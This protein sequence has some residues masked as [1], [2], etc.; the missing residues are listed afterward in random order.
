MGMTST[1]LEAP[2]DSHSANNGVVEYLISGVS[3]LFGV[4]TVKAAVTSSQIYFK[5]IV[6]VSGLTNLTF[7]SAASGTSLFSLY[8]SDAGHQTIPLGHTK[9]GELLE[10]TS[11]N[12]VTVLGNIQTFPVLEGHAVPEQWQ[13]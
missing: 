12:D 4:V 5:G 13:I 1:A 8:F 3:D 9:S 10:L 6:H 7:K 2:Y 11:L